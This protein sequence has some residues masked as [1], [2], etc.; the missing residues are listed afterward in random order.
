MRKI[1]LAKTTGFCFGVQR[2]VDIVLEAR[3]REAGPI[4][5]LGPIVHN[6]QVAGK[7][8]A[9]GGEMDHVELTDTD[10]RFQRLAGDAFVLAMGSFSPLLAKPLGIDLP[11]YPAKGY[12]VTLP[13]KDA[14]MAH[15]VS[16]TDD[17]ARMFRAATA[18]HTK[19]I[20]K[21]FADALTREQFEALAEILRALQDHLR[22]G[23]RRS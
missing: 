7:L 9:E 17:G 2:A 15:Q 22:A 12:S 13:V 20:K 11:V 5:S 23:E 19:A 3:S 16:L 6:D 8:R 10:G 18:P 21:H 14:A 1:V 4:T